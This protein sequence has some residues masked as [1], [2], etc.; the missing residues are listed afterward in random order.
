MNKSSFTTPAGSEPIPGYFLRKRLG[1]GGYGEV[2]LADA[3][4]GLQKAVKLIYGNVD[5]SR[6]ANELKSLERVRRV[7]HP[8]LLS[9]ERIEIVRG[10][11][12]IVTELAECSLQD[13]FEQFRRQGVAGIPRTELL[14]FMR[15]T[16]DA[17]DF[18]AQK[19]SL[20]HLDIKPGNL[21]IIADRIK[22]ADFGLVKDLHG[23][24]QSL[25]AGLTPAYSAPEV[26]DGRPDFR[27]DQYSLAVV[28]MELLTGNLPFKGQTPGELARQHLNLSPELD[29]LPPA[30][31][32]IVQRAL[33]KNPLD[34]Y[35]TCRQFVE[36]LMKVRN[37]V[38]PIQSKVEATESHHFEHTQS[39]VTIAQASIHAGSQ[40]AAFHPALSSE[41]FACQSSSVPAMFIGIGGMGLLALKELRGDLIQNVDDPY[42]CEDHEWLGIDTTSEALIDV[43]SGQDL[44]A[45]PLN[46]VVELPIQSPQAYR[47]LST[48]QFAPL[49]RRWLY[50]IP[51]SRKTDG[52]RPIATL[53]L[54]AN[55]PALCKIVEQKIVRLIEFHKN[56]A[57]SASP[58]HV[59]VIASLHGGTGSA[60]L[61]ELGFIV[62]RCFIKHGYTNYRLCAVASAATTSNSQAVNLASGNALATLSELAYLMDPQ[63]ETPSLD[64]RTGFALSS[65]RPFDWVTLIDGGMYEDREAIHLTTR[66]MARHISL[67]CQ[68]LSSAALAESRRSLANEPMGW[69]RTADASTVRPVQAITPELLAGWCSWQ[70][71]NTALGFFDICRP[72]E[73]SNSNNT[74]AYQFDPTSPTYRSLTDEARDEFT[75]RVLQELGLYQQTEQIFNDSESIGK[76]ARR[77][78][79]DPQVQEIQLSNDLQTWQ[80]TVI[81]LTEAKFYN[82]NQ[83][84]RIQLRVI[85]AIQDYSERNSPQLVEQ[86]AAFSQLLGDADQLLSSIRDYLDEYCMNCIRFFEHTKAAAEQLAK[87]LEMW[88]VSALNNEALQLSIAGLTSLPSPIQILHLRVVDELTQHLHQRLLTCIEQA[89]LQLN[90]VEATEAPDQ[91]ASTDKE[92]IRDYGH[93]LRLAFEGVCQGC[94]ELGIA[95]DDF[96]NSR[97]ALSV[98]K[99]AD[100]QQHLPPLAYVGS[101]AYRL[102]ITSE[103]QRGPID[104]ELRS[105]GIREHTTLLPGATCLGTQLVCDITRLNIAQLIATLWRPSGATL[106]LAER[107]HTRVDIDWPPVSQLLVNTDGGRGD[108]VYSSE[109]QAAG[110]SDSLLNDEQGRTLFSPVVP[111]EPTAQAPAVN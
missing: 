109:D 41:E 93:L 82:W 2:W 99:F 111:V 106:N 68:S 96:L 66:Q 10:K 52:V 13:R 20:Q 69:L 70:A 83:L 42:T 24:C 79:H 94:R 90:S 25:V 88:R 89:P 26:F 102:L 33:S 56:S 29:P 91:S 50:N 23:N 31:R 92:D 27:S 105:A 103:G 9:L 3:P 73:T 61:C 57:A 100:I 22:V 40:K 37:A 63:Q 47:K 98:I 30:D 60:L 71:L 86:F 84:E 21:L 44:Q 38:L 67:D 75:Q 108:H 43:T 101:Q 104:T 77:L 55:Y 76:W 53:S 48:E 95:Q 62:R 85:E 49:S 110:A 80:K 28:Y 81:Q 45:I 17:L 87:Q 97:Y 32:M 36:Q 65:A 19:H 6:A 35:P 64:Y 107:L 46:C 72:P 39:T 14:D 5:E 8:F 18:L 78:S 11:V 34:R 7:H 16:A 54:I 51:R 12:I 15:D 4:G 1:A 59:Y 58:L 74:P